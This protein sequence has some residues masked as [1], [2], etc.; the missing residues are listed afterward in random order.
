[1][2][3]RNMR[4]FEERYFPNGDTGI[5]HIWEE[6]KDEAEELGKKWAK[7]TMEKVREI[8]NP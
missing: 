3:I 1:M 4:Q 7:E 5:P 6:K 8:L 2:S